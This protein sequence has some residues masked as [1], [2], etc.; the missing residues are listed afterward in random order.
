MSPVLVEPRAIAIRLYQRH[1]LS[2]IQPHLESFLQDCAVASLSRHPGMLAALDRGLYHDPYALVAHDGDKVHGFLLLA[3]VKS[4]FFGRFLVSLPYVN[5]GGIVAGDERIATQ[6]IDAAVKLAN[7]LRVRHL[8]LRHEKEVEHAAL[9]ATL[10]SKVH[11]RLALP[12]TSEELWSQLHSKVRNQIR[13]AQKTN[14]TACWGG[15]NLLPE[16]YDVFSQN[17]RDLGTPVFG[18][19]LFR[20][21]LRQFGAHAEVCVVRFENRVV[22]SALCLHGFG[23]SEVPSTVHYVLTTI[24][25]RTCSSIGTCYSVR[26]KWG[27]RLLTLGIECRQQHLSLQE[28]VGRRRVS[29][30]LAILP[31]ERECIGNEAR[32]PSLPN[33]HP[34][35]ATNARGRDADSRA[36]DC[37]WHPLRDRNNIFHLPM[38]G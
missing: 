38:S 33:A 28:T 17:M 13:K 23:V 2:G 34:V 12:R 5:S 35:L 18:Q 37:T 26:S 31:A 14:L 24:R 3:L 6:L 20:S 36:D 15:E 1:E 30:C 22:A 29:R 10:T 11:M 16:F 32:E 4:V 25:T 8:E 27:K 19:K 9:T 7:Q 21:L